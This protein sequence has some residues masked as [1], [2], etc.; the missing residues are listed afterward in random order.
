M[1][2]LCSAWLLALILGVG[3]WGCAPEP[4]GAV[5]AP[6]AASSEG[7]APARRIVSLAPSLTEILFAL[8]AGDRL[9]AATEY[10]DYPPA[11]RELPRI[12][13]ITSDTVDLER[14]LTAHPDLVVSIGGDQADVARA[15][16][17]LGL[18]VE[19]LPSDDLDDLFVTL[20]ELGRLTGHPEDATR[21]ARR[22]RQRIEEVEARVGALPE[23]ERPRVFYQVWDRPLMTAGPETFV[24]EL[25][26]RA[27]GRN[28]FSDVESLYPQISPEAVIARDPEVILAPH[29]HGEP[30]DLEDFH[31][32][33]GWSGLDAVRT[34]RVH[35]V[36]GDWVARLGPRLVDALEVFASL[37]HPSLYPEPE[38]GG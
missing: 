15:L 3:L 10:C 26:E 5:P 20:E 18:R 9:V 31:R 27:G 16:G 22:L 38:A 21:L 30:V 4:D 13:G 29:R 19:M 32:R 7:S 35:T 33:P 23:A 1:P 6:S 2:S 17:R 12:G 24:G 25:I 28:V 14:V 36:D 37:L 11:A 34:G 8:D